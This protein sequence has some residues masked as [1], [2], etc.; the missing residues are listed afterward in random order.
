M[1]VDSRFSAPPSSDYSIEATHNVEGK[2]NCRIERARGACF[3]SHGT[4]VNTLLGNAVL[5]Y[6]VTPFVFLSRAR[7]S[8]DA[9]KTAYY[10]LSLSVFPSLL[11]SLSTRI[12]LIPNRCRVMTLARLRLLS[13]AAFHVRQMS[14]KKSRERDSKKKGDRP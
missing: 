4:L 2:G 1:I 7:T 14:C 11:P 8:L 13:S 3:S 5:V 12:S 6:V 9:P 10:L